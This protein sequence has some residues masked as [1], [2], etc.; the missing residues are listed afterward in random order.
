MKNARDPALQTLFDAAK[1]DFDEGPF[2]ADIMAKVDADRRR[3]VSTWIAVAAVLAAAA[4]FFVPGIVDTV[5]LVSRFLPQSLVELEMT[6]SVFEPIVA[7]LNS[8][9]TIVAL[10][11]LSVWLLYRKVF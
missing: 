5:G 7:P 3:S 10:A 1:T 4:W 2:V 8:V 9:S 11:L 6:G